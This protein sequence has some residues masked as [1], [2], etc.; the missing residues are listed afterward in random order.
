MRLY[1]LEYALSTLQISFVWMI[2]AI[3]AWHHIL[4][5]VIPLQYLRGLFLHD[6]NL[7]LAKR[8]GPGEGTE[9]AGVDV[10]C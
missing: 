2:A 9:G 8:N 3:P 6:L 4:H 10:Q 1:T 7:T 5:S